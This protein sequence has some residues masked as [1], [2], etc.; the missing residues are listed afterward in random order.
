MHAGYP[1]PS[2]L[3]NFKHTQD[4]FDAYWEY[5][6]LSKAWGDSL[7]GSSELHALVLQVV[8][9]AER[10]TP[11]PP[12][13]VPPFAYEAWWVKMIRKILTLTEETPSKTIHLPRTTSEGSGA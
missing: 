13:K 2:S 12:D 3:L 11:K 8:R 9:D 4:T 6:T 1:I 5:A 7:W 10:V